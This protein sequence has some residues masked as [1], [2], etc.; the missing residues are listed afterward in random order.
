[1]QNNIPISREVQEM[2]SSIN[3]VIKNLGID[4]YLVGAVARDCHLSR[5][6]GWQPSRKTL[7]VDL[8][9]LVASEE[10]Y[11]QLKESLL[12]TKL[13][14][15]HRTEPIKLFYRN[16]V[17]LDLLPFGGIEENGVT[18]LT[19]P[20]FMSLE[21]PGFELL[22]QY[23]NLFEVNEQLKLD[24]CSLEGIVL[25]KLIAWD[26]RPERTK[27]LFDIKHIIHYYFELTS[28]DIYNEHF[29]LMKLYPT[30]ESDYIQKVSAHVIGRKIANYLIEDK[31]LKQRIIQ[32]LHKR[33]DDW[34][35][36][37]L[38]GLSK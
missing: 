4:F 36:F 3:T 1:M 16:E 20:N 23:K 13:F 12:K 6:P 32:I 21:M 33:E 31:K 11:I 34:W 7:D 17:E 10:Q 18:I 2:L 24:I 30:H 22:N 25:L 27:D 29:D 15:E 19:K 38:L 37:I 28:D 35:P 9:V 26:D 14:T 8:A 5:L